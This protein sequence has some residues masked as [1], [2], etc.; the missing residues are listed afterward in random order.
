MKVFGFFKGSSWSYKEK[1]E[2]FEEYK[3]IKN[4]IPKEILISYLKTLKPVAAAPMSIY[5]MFTN[6]YLGC[7]LMY[8]DG[9]FAFTN[10]FI[11]YYE[12]YDIGVP[13]DYEN[14]LLSKPEFSKYKR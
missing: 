8:E 3:Q 4:V 11:H 9:E 13:I 5:D 14:Y 10:D 6:K 7:G 2:E 1:E 12:H